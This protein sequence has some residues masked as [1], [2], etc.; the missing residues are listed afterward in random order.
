MKSQIIIIITLF[1]LSFYCPAQKLLENSSNIN[2]HFKVELGKVS[3]F[4][5]N[6]I[7]YQANMISIDS[8]AFSSNLSFRLED[9]LVSDKTYV[10]MQD[11]TFFD[12]QLNFA[13]GALQL[14]FFIENLLGFNN[15]DFAIEPVLD[16]DSG[17]DMVYFSHEANF[18]IGASIVYNF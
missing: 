8:G 9:E 1:L 15:S 12:V 2:G 6:E 7:T 11:I 16:R 14:G 10:L 3:F 13:L 17:V 4:N 5:V 18:L